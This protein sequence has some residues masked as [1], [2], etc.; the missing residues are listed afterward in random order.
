MNKAVCYNTIYSE[1]CLYTTLPA[2]S[3]ITLIQTNKIA[4]KTLKIQ[5][6]NS[7]YTMTCTA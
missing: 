3:E 5:A 6:V 4:E 1:A 7:M 2:I